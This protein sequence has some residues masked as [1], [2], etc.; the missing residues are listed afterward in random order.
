MP[1]QKNAGVTKSAKDLDAAFETL[2]AADLSKHINK[3]KAL[4]PRI[5]SALTE[6]ADREARA[7][8]LAEN[9]KYLKK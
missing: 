6:A 8:I 5:Q 4:L 7:K 2:M 3:V 9:E 1:A